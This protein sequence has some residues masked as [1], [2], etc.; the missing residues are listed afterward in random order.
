MRHF[1]RPERAKLHGSESYF[2]AMDNIVIAAKASECAGR[3]IREMETS[4]PVNESG[5]P[6]RALQAVRI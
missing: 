3:S 1:L 2:V 4:E 5:A 6:E